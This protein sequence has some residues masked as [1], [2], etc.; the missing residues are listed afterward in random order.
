MNELFGCIHA[1]PPAT[2]SLPCTEDRA[3]LRSNSSADASGNTDGAGLSGPALFFPHPSATADERSKWAV[4]QRVPVP[5]TTT[6]A[7]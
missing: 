3:L 7:E 4:D 6:R 1:P 2:V 5:S